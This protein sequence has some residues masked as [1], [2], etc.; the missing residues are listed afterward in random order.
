MDFSEK[1]LV[2]NLQLW[3]FCSILRKS[4]NRAAHVLAF[5]NYD[6][7]AGQLLEIPTWVSSGLFIYSIEISE[8]NTS[9]NLR[10][11]ENKLAQIIS[12]IVLAIVAPHSGITFL[13]RLGARN[14]SGR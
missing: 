6:V 8:R 7:N 2:L 4:Q 1:N 12:K 10:D 11:F 13:M 3:N 5:S 9:Y 14:H